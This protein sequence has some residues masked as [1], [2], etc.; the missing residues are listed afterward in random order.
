MII[1]LSLSF[2]VLNPGTTRMQEIV[3]QICHEREISSEIKM[4]SFVCHSSRSWR[5]KLI[6]MIWEVLAVIKPHLIFSTIPKSANNDDR[7]KYIYVARD[8]KDVAVS[9]FH[10]EDN[11][12]ECYGFNGSREAFYK[13]FIEGY[14]NV[15]TA[16][17]K[18]IQDSLGFWIP[19]R[20]WILDSGFWIL[21][22]W[23]LDSGFQSLVAFRI[24][25]TV[26][27]IPKPRVSYSISKIFR[28]PQSGFPSWSDF[29][30]PQGKVRGIVEDFVLQTQVRSLDIRR[31]RRG[32]CVGKLQWNPKRRIIYAWLSHF[33]L[34]ETTDICFF[35]IL[36]SI[37]GQ[38]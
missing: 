1:S 5:R 10:F 23:Y 7:C 11:M 24:Q 35:H 17:Y 25:W 18:Q 22:Q 34:K 37:V 32:M 4:Y 19:R 33:P 38:H 12:K 36:T 3:W 9:Y 15:F 8:P 27:R 28:I 30:K 6:F 16:P 14:G 26:F 21:C 20:N 13:L 29:S 31:F 2:T